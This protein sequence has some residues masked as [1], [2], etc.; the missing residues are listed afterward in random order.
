MSAP[1]PKSSDLN[2]VLRTASRQAELVVA[3]IIKVIQQQERFL[4]GVYEAFKQPGWEVLNPQK[5]GSPAYEV[6]TWRPVLSGTVALGGCATVALFPGPALLG[7]G[8]LS[9]AAVF[10]YQLAR[11][12]GFSTKQGLEILQSIKPD[13]SKLIGLLIETKKCLEETEETSDPQEYRRK[14][15]AIQALIRLCGTYLYLRLRDSAPVK[16]NTLIEILAQ[17]QAL[18]SNNDEMYFHYAWMRSKH[19]ESPVA[20]ERASEPEN[21]P[22]LDLGEPPKETAREDAISAGIAIARKLSS[23]ESPPK[24]RRT[25]AKKTKGSLQAMASTPKQAAS[26]EQALPKS[27]AV[28]PESADPAKPTRTEAPGPEAKSDDDVVSERVTVNGPVAPGAAFLGSEFVVSRE[29]VDENFDD[30]DVEVYN[31]LK[32]M[33]EVQREDLEDPK[34]TAP[35]TE[36]DDQDDFG[37]EPEEGGLEGDSFDLPDDEDDLPDVE[38]VDGDDQSGEEPEGLDDFLEQLDDEDDKK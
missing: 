12:V 9:L 36:A 26:P 3:D 19:F 5:I 15:A 11:S 18:F 38:D 13:L 25:P 32:R 30:E 29:H 17:C 21:Q 37:D 33:D 27:P 28:K 16:I 7:L 10:G 1:N 2:T 23:M 31:E 14:R 6:L 4:P 22:V 35:G 34:G 20:Q 24:R 8:V